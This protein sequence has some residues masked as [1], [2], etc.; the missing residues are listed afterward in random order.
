MAIP[1]NNRM[2]F[3]FAEFDPTRASVGSPNLGYQG[4]L[5]GQMLASGT[6]TANGIY[7][8]SSADQAGLYFGIGSQLHRMAIKW[9]AVNKTTRIY[10]QPLADNGTAFAAGVLAFAGPAT[11]AGTIYLYIAGERLTIAVAQG[12][13]ATIVGA[14]VQAAVTAWVTSPVTALNTTGSVAITARNA[15]LA[16]NDID[17]KFNL[18]DGESFPTG[19]TCT[20][21]AMAAGAVNPVLTS[22]IAAWGDVWY[23]FIVAPY[24]DTTSL[25]AVEAELNLRFGP[26]RKIR[27]HYFSART[28]NLASQV[29]FGAARNSPHVTVFD[30][31][32]FPTPPCELAAAAVATLIPSI[33]VDPALP[34]HTMAVAGV[35]GPS[36][37][38]QRNYADNN[39][40]LFDGISPFTIDQFGNVR[41][42]TVITMYQKNDSLADDTAYLLY[43]TMATG[44]YLLYS[45]V[46]ELALKY[47]RAKIAN[48][49]TLIPSDQVILTPKGGKAMAVAWA[50]RMQA[51]R[52]LIEDLDQFKTDL[53]VAR[54][55]ND[56]NRMDFRMSPNYVNPYI[57]G[58]LTIQFIL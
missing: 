53:I 55:A 57:T 13:T 7:L 47:G 20:I 25:T 10:G 58:A 21:T 1:N 29:G 17:L 6:K 54:N 36:A 49:D 52:G 3:T 50:Q 8:L 31:N 4:I 16:G 2:P 34:V 48:D 37:A 27:A 26:S 12:D 23:N 28:G 22:A 5:L 11:A 39:A 38:N 14:A 56:V 33:E 40:L 32:A 46:N 30:G 24:V 51:T 44:D 42:A 19:I 43:N 41:L 9:F 35:R 45:F 18:N 15:G